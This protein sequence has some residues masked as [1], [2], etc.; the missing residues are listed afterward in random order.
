MRRSMC[1][2]GGLPVD[3]LPLSALIGTAQVID[4]R[5]GASITRSD[6]EA[7]LV[8]GCSIVLFKT[9]NSALWRQVGFSESYVAL[10]GMR[11]G[12]SWRK[13]SKRWG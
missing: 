11:P 10:S 4:I 13:A 8:E 9:R 2:E 5:D 3:R 6:V 12:T 1:F 7:H